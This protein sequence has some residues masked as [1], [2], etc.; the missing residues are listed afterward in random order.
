MNLN[1]KIANSIRSPTHKSHPDAC[2]GEL[3]ECEVV[4]IVLFEARGNGSEVFELVE[5][6]L[7]EVSETIEEMT[8]GWKVD[9]P[10]QGFDV[11]P[12]ATFSRALAQSITVVGTIAEQ[13]LAPAE[14]IK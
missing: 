11:G 12:S 2:G 3:D 13:D 14:S 4:G 7:D 6:A 8:E 1:L 9:P 5:E 10:R